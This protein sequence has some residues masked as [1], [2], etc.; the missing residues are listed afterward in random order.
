ME[1]ATKMRV[2]YKNQKHHFL[3]Q[4]PVLIIPPQ[5]PRRNRKYSINQNAC[6]FHAPNKGDFL[7]K[8]K[9]QGCKIKFISF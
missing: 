5:K 8:H 4:N 1:Y 7:D 2:V 9:Y 6:P 3:Y